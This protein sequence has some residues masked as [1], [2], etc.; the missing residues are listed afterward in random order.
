[1]SQLELMA[2]Q[3]ALNKAGATGSKA[4]TGTD[5]VTPADGYYFFALQAMATTVVAAQGD[6]SGAVNADLTTIT[7]IPAGVIIYGKWDSITLTS[8]QMIGYYAKG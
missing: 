2:A 1:M 3:V 5:A 8:G 6:V 4:I 7:G